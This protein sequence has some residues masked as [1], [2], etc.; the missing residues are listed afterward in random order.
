MARAPKGGTTGRNGE[1]Y[2]GGQFLPSSADTVKGSTHSGRKDAG[3]NRGS[4]KVRV[5]PFKWTLP[6]SVYHRAIYRHA[7]TGITPERDAS[8]WIDSEAPVLV[9][10]PGIRLYDKNRA[11]WDELVEAFNAGY[12]WEVY[13]AEIGGDR[14]R[15][16]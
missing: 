13:D 8:G 5:S 12:R 1:R 9:G 15:F 11:Y 16:E 7:G 2:E 6:P 14:I 4:R 10:C 3:R